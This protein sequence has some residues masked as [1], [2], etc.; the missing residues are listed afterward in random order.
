MVQNPIVGE[1]EEELEDLKEK[2]DGG[3]HFS[4]AVRG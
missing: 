3:G 4:R 1:P 2:D